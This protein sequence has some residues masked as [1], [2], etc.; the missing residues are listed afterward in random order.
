M[1]PKVFIVNRSSHNFTTAERFGT[2][3]FM[4]DGPMNRYEV[5]NMARQF[6]SI[7]KDSEPGD[8]IVTCGLSN[9]NIIA[10]VIFVLLH[11]KLN[12]LLFKSG[13]Y[14]ERNLDF[15]IVRREGR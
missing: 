12:L 15:S 6:W 2:L 13:E 9:M 7:L 11:E 3:V 4:S 5:N 8:Y 10:C 14:M 1:R